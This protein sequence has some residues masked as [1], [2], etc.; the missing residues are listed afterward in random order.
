MRKDYHQEIGFPDIEKPTGPFAVDA[1]SHA[2]QESNNDRYGGFNL[3]TL[4][5]LT[6]AMYKRSPK[7][8]TGSQKGEETIPHVFEIT[9]ENGRVVKLG[10]RTNYDEKH[11]IVL[12]IK[13]YENLLKTAWINVKGDAHHTLDRGKYAEP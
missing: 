9:V 8:A 11:D 10:A 3:P 1:T 2:R 6:E 5:K 13:P 4:V 12:I 7:K